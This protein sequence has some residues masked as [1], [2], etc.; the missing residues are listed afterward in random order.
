MIESDLD[1]HV[2]NKVA[3]FFGKPE[4][5][6]GNR[7][8]IKEVS[9]LMLLVNGNY[10]LVALP[11]LARCEQILLLLDLCQED[12]ERFASGVMIASTVASSPEIA[13]V[14]F[15]LQHNGEESEAQC[16][17]AIAYFDLSSFA[18]NP[19]LAELLCTIGH[20]KYMREIS[21]HVREEN[22]TMAVDILEAMLQDPETRAVF[23]K[24]SGRT[25][26]EIALRDLGSRLE[27]GRLAVRLESVLHTFEQQFGPST[28]R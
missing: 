17:I 24:N 18:E 1:K 12:P 20:E 10:P 28:E 21:P 8:K 26:I 19:A 16:L 11:A 22:E 23:L 3:Q 27:P 25:E 9:D 2:A 6:R 4:G 14:F 7:A 5:R 15:A 13:N